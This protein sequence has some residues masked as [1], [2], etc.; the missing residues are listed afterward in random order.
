MRVDAV[1]IHVF[2]FFQKL[3]PGAVSA[4]I[5]GSTFA[6]QG[7]TGPSGLEREG[8]CLEVGGRCLLGN[9]EGDPAGAVRE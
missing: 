3:I 6:L 9:V 2:D 1:H 5:L 7:Q 4:R 8:G